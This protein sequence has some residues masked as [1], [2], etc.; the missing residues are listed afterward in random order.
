MAGLMLCSGGDRGWSAQ[1][2]AVVVWS[3]WWS[4]VSNQIVRYLNSTQA[5]M[6]A[7][8]DI[9]VLDDNAVKRW[10][11]FRYLCQWHC[12]R[13]FWGIF[14]ENKKTKFWLNQICTFLQIQFPLI[15]EV[16]TELTV[17]ESYKHFHFIVVQNF[18]ST[19]SPPHVCFVT[20]KQLLLH[21]GGGCGSGRGVVRPPTSQLPP[22]HIRCVL[23]QDT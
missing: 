5:K 6:L 10:E 17:Q 23:G 7:Q 19:S 1:V 4:V 3:G 22:V 2:W 9:M 18:L 14:W 21:P 15:H 13:R 20:V 11:V 16:K 8:G 12:E